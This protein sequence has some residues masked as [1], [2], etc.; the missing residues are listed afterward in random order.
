MMKDLLN[1]FTDFVI[2]FF[3]LLITQLNINLF[4]EIMLCKLIMWQCD[5]MTYQFAGS[6]SL[7]KKSPLK[8]IDSFSYSY[9]NITY[10]T[11]T[12][13]LTFNSSFSLFNI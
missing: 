10:I 12:K 1:N 3:P 11:N 4:T 8:N 6:L 13:K 2:D 9:L 5:I 7:D